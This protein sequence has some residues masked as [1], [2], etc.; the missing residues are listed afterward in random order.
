[1]SGPEKVFCFILLEKKLIVVDLDPLG[2]VRFGQVGS[3]LI[4]A[5][6]DQTSLTSEKFLK[7]FFLKMVHFAFDTY[8]FKKFLNTLK[9]TDRY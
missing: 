1:M 2:P 5:D 4:V 3:G 6:P 8:S 7:F 9:E